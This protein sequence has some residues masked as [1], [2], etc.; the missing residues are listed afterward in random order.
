MRKS[1]IWLIG[2]PLLQHRKIKKDNGLTIFKLEFVL[3]AT[4]SKC[5]KYEK[6]PPSVCPPCNHQ[7]KNFDHVLRCPAA[8][9]GNLEKWNE[10]KKA[11]NMNNSCP[12]AL[13][14]FDKGFVTRLTGQ[15]N[16]P[17]LGPPP[18][19]NDTIGLKI[20]QAIIDQGKIGWGQALC[21]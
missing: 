14:A 19:K 7:S 10:C 17:V 8:I 12:A 4:M 15:S 1:L 6:E 20:R 5:H 21:G 2:R 13:Q 9:I 3:F 11:I 16:D 18:N